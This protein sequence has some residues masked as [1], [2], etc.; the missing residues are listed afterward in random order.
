M[1]Q[2]LDQS[3]DSKTLDLILI[4]VLVLLIVFATALKELVV[5]LPY[6]G[7]LRYVA[8]GAM[9]LA[10]YLL[11]T[12]R[13]LSYRYTLYAEEK[14]DR[15]KGT[16][17]VHRMVGDRGRAALAIEPGELLALVEPGSAWGIASISDTKQRI[18]KKKLSLRSVKT[19]HTLFYEK[20]GK[21]YALRI[22]PSKKLA[23]LLK[24]AV[25]DAAAAR[26][27]LRP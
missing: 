9:L 3:A 15:P 27:A 1:H 24:E 26:A 7:V 8:F 13:I 5:A 12:R 19:A 2:E 21:L 20:K 23:R 22:H 4:G 18:H 16:F 25:Q 11:Y 6:G 10:L 14:R 17:L